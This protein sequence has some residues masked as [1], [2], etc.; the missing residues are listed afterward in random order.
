MIPVRLALVCSAVVTVCACRGN[1]TENT[2]VVPIRNMYDQPRYDP[3][4]RSD[5][6]QDG[7]TMRSLPAHTVAAEMENDLDVATGRIE[8]NTGPEGHWVSRVPVA[9]AQEFGGG[10]AMLDR[11]Q[12]RYNIYCSPCHGF[13]GEGNGMVASRA[14]ELGYAALAPP[15]FGTDTL[16]HVPDGHVFAVITHGIRNMPA[17]GHSIPVRDRWAIV[18]YVRALQLRLAALPRPADAGAGQ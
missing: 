9:V 7:R 6:F 3:Q 8:G 16:Y 13:T 4:S 11:G 18:A 14:Q 2:P 1:Q 5:F 15:S 17:Y 12:D 10:Q